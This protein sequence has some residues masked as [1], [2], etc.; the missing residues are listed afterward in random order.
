MNAAATSSA[1][2]PPSLMRSRASAI[3]S[4]V[5]LQISLSGLN[6]AFTNCRRSCPVS[7]PALD[8]C[9]KAKVKLSN[10]S[11][12]PWDTSPSICRVGRRSSAAVPKAS[13]VCDPFARSEVSNGVSAP[14]TFRSLTSS[15]AFSA[16]PSMVPKDVI[17]CSIWALYFTTTAAPALN[18]PVTAPIAVTA[19]CNPTFAILPILEIPLLKPVPSMLVSNFK[20]PS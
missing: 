6:P 4:P 1:D 20:A 14:M 17:Y 8:T 2:I 13:S 11:L 18:A 19:V 12:L 7:F 16:L 5:F 10:R 3:L 9:A 15:V